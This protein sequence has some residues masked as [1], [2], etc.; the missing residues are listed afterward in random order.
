VPVFDPDFS[1]HECGME[2]LYGE[3]RI[4][5]R[6][7]HQEWHPTAEYAD[8]A[9]EDHQSARKRRRHAPLKRPARDGVLALADQPP[10]RQAGVLFSCGCPLLFRGP[11]ATMKRKCF[12]CGEKKIREPETTAA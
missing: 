4:R 6:C 7:G 1:D 10:E 9:I 3:F 12:I 8:M 11:S 2:E 5:C